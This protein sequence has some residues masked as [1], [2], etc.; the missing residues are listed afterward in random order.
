MTHYYTFELQ[1]L[2]MCVAAEFGMHL[3]DIFDFSPRKQS[4]EDSFVGVSPYRY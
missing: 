1:F 2:N 4:E 3:D